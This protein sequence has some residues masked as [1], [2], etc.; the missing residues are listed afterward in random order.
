[1]DFIKRLFQRLFPKVNITRKGLVI[2]N[3]L[4]PGRFLNY[5]G[6]IWMFGDG[7]VGEV[8]KEN[9]KN[10]L[11]HGTL[12]W[13]IKSLLVDGENLEEFKDLADITIKM[14]RNEAMNRLSGVRYASLLPEEYTYTYQMWISGVLLEDHYFTKG[15]KGEIYENRGNNKKTI[16]TEEKIKEYLKEISR[17]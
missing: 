14:E 2:N 12:W 10:Y 6:R 8:E 9:I 16:V 7:Y 15:V 3:S 5:E 4:I 11:S 1:M 17:L 13:G